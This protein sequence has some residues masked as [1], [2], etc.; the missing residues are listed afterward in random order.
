M[1]VLIALLLL[2]QNG[3]SPDQIALLEAVRAAFTVQEAWESYSA[4]IRPSTD[5]VFVAFTAEGETVYGSQ[6]RLAEIRADFDEGEADGEVSYQ[7]I[8]LDAAGEETQGNGEFLF[9]VEDGD[10]V[11]GD[12]EDE[13]EPATP[14]EVGMLQP[15]FRGGTVPAGLLDF[16][17]AIFDLGVTEEDDQRI[18]RYEL[19]LDVPRSL[20]QLD[21]DLEDFAA[22]Y[23]DY[24]DPEDLEAALLEN[25][26]LTLRVDVDF[27]TGEITGLE[28]LLDFDVQ[29]GDG[30]FELIYGYIETI[31]YSE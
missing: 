27:D 20:P 16:T 31:S 29:M 13:F 30:A 7:R 10:A 19:N 14:E 12:S 25:G 6:Q 24:V 9:E 18:Q 23:S 17:T 26:T 8:G 15:I 11:T 3:L 22:A 4:T 5:D 2:L 28:L 1:S 21:F